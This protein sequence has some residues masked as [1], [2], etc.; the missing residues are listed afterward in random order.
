[1]ALGVVARARRIELGLGVE[2]LAG[3]MDV[4]ARQVRRIERGEANVTFDTL[5]ALGTGLS[6]LPS[7]L[8]ASVERAL[9]LAGLERPAADGVPLKNANTAMLR[10]AH[11]AR[12]SDPKT[13]PLHH[14]VGAAVSRLRQMGRLTQRELA[15]RAGVSLSA[16]QS[17]ESGRHAPTTITLETLAHALHCDVADLV[18]S[19]HASDV[20]YVAGSS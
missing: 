17:V 11:G 9:A 1:V 5:S 19:P 20:V 8:L 12:A 2:Q 3:R 4:D 18:G 14:W 13:V 6:R 15:D 10:A 7:E 16:V